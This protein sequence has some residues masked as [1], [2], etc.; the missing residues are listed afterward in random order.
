MSASD[1][2]SEGQQRT[3][4]L[5][6]KL[7][8]GEILRER[9]G[10]FPIYL[11]DDIFGELDSSRRN[12]LMNHLP[13]DAQKLITTTNVDWLSDDLGMEKWSRYSVSEGKVS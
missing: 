5:A 8:Q 7:A 6:L 13:K 2:A 4:A 1:Y 10:K 3:M 12:A 9:G 11:L